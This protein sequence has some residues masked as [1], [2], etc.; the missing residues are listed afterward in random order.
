ML[1]QLK[2][3]TGSEGSETEAQK[4]LAPSFKPTGDRNLF[5]CIT[6]GKEYCS[7]SSLLHH[8]KSHQPDSIKCS[9]CHMLWLHPPT[10]IICPRCCKTFARYYSLKRHIMRMHND[11]NQTRYKVKW[12]S[13]CSWV[14]NDRTKYEEHLVRHT[15]H[16]AYSTGVFYCMS[17]MGKTFR[18]MRAFDTHTGVCILDLKY[19][20]QIC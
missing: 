15:K 19:G 11:T 7:K 14:F 12:V 10:P 20:C 2:G 17:K 9:T 5:S 16:P 6:C 1:L 13:G 18:V 3:E 4:E 8:H